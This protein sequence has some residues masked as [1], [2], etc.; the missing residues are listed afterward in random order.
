MPADIE[1]R[2]LAAFVKHMNGCYTGSP[3]DHPKWP[4][5]WDGF[6]AREAEQK[7][8]GSHE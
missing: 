5:F 7:K 8:G 1:S 2:A 4:A 6:R 3:K